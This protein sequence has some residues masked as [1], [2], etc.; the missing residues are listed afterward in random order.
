MQMKAFLTKASC[1]VACLLLLFCQF[2]PMT[3]SAEEAALPSMS[4]CTA[5]YLYHLEEDAVILSKNEEAPLDAGP[6]VKVM[7]GLLFCQIMEHRL[8]ES[9]TLTKE[10]LAGA[11]GYR[12]NLQA[13]DVVTVEQLLYAAICGSYN[14]AYYVLAHLA[15]GDLDGF[16]E[17]MNVTAKE[18]GATD[19][20]FTDP[21]G[22]DDKSRTT[23][24]DLAKIAL[25]AAQNQ[26]YMKICDT[27]KYHMSGTVLMDARDIHNRNALISSS[28]TTKYFNKRCHGMSAG[29]TDRGGNCVVTLARED[30]QTYLCIVLGGMEAENVNYGY[31]IVNRLVNWVYSAY[32]YMEVISPDTVVCTVPVTVSDMIKEIE[33]K[34]KESLSCR[35]PAGLVIG[36][37]ITYSI[38][39]LHTSL[40]APV[41]EGTFMGYV[42]VLYDGRVLGTVPLYVAGDVERSNI[43]SSLM[44]IQALTQNRKILSGGI[45][46]TIV[47]IAW[48]V[49]E[50]VIAARRRRKWDKY[51]SR[52]LHLPS[53][54]KNKK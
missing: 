52:K 2:A 54:S 46:F 30:G 13:G 21:S 40:E 25:A 4:E 53:E 10:M 37:D 32:S 17:L 42:A 14:D 20:V 26:L 33:V 19:T 6:T 44:S 38:R 47:L 9:V 39:L 11:V 12:L 23:V 31:T 5:A 27:A 36:E 45:F 41:T 8:Y 34:T 7:S 16:V 3:V 29:A 35:L 15:A 28:S 49:T 50:N 22:V 43:I 24:K 18:L 1:T 51:F 48:I